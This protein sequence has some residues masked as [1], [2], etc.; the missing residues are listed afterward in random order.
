MEKK[1]YTRT[2]RKT[3]TIKELQQLVA[4]LDCTREEAHA[5]ADKYGLHHHAIDTLR[6][7]LGFT[8]KQN[9]YLTKDVID[10]MVQVYIDNPEKS[11][12]QIFKEHKEF[13]LTSYQ[14]YYQIL[15]NRGFEMN[16]TRDFWTIF[17]QKQLVEMHEKKHM[18]FKQIAEAFGN[19]K[20]PG[21]VQF[22]YNSIKR[23]GFTNGL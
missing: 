9:D 6:S 10:H 19:R 13:K 3:L 17:K 23:I 21:A 15:R 14:N 4:K 12:Y 8:Q 2:H 5:L 18:T 7:I 16:R 22:K 20:T 11:A 1:K